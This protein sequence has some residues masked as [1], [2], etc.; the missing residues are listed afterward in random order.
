MEFAATQA[1]SAFTDYGQFTL[2]RQ[3]SFLSL[4][5]QPPLTEVLGFKLALISLSELAQAK[6]LECF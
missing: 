2:R 3:V 5:F 1:K 6:R 4:R